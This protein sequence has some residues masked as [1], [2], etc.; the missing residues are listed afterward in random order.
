MSKNLK[1]SDSDKLPAEIAEWLEI[2]ASCMGDNVKH[3]DV[4]RLR[5]YLTTHPDA[6]RDAGDLASEALKRTIEC[7]TWSKY[8]AECVKLG[9]DQ[10]RATL[11]YEQA[12]SVERLL[13]DQCVLSWVRL[14]RLEEKLSNATKDSHNRESGL[15]WDRR[16]TSAQHRY[17]QALI[18]L[19]KVRKLKLPNITAIQADV[20]YVNASDSPVELQA[21]RITEGTADK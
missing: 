8:Q 12:N 9:A 15:Y 17:N 4:L 6:W 21:R 10:L 11:G 5:D 20:A 3:E 2:C 19:A 18:S 14:N 1:K 16:V 7:E 13:I